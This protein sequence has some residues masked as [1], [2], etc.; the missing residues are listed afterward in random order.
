[1]PLVLAYLTFAAPTWLWL[2]AAAAALLVALHWLS[3][4]RAP[5][6]TFPATRLLAE[7][8]P[9]PTERRRLRDWLLLATRLIILAALIAGFARP[10]W[11]GAR[12]SSAAPAPRHA[13]LL[14]DRS[15]SMRRS[16]QGMRLFEQAKQRAIERLRALQRSGVYVSLV[17]IDES[18]ASLL[19]EPTRNVAVLIDRLRSREV[20]FQRGRAGRALDEARALHERFAAGTN[21]SEPLR[22][23]IISD[24]Q[25]PHWP[26]QRLARLR[27]RGMNVTVHRI[28]GDTTNVALSRLRVR[29]HPPIQHQP[30]EATVRITNFTDKTRRVTARLTGESTKAPAPSHSSASESAKRTGGKEVTRNALTITSPR[31]RL[32]LEPGERRSLT[33]RVTFSRPGPAVLR[34]SLVD[35]ADALPADDTTGAA[36]HVAEAQPVLMITRAEATPDSARY[37]LERALAATHDAAPPRFDVR[38]EPPEAFTTQSFSHEPSTRDAPG[39]STDRAAPPPIVL[40]VDAGGLDAPTREALAGHV[41][42]GGRVFWFVDSAA[43]ADAFNRFA[44]TVPRKSADSRIPRAVWHANT[45][46]TLGSARFD[47]PP[48]EVFGG[49]SR[50]GLLTSSFTRYATLTD[51]GRSRALLRA[52][53]SAALMASWRVGRGRVLVSGLD[54]AP[55]SSDFVKTPWFV[56]FVHESLE[57]LTRRERRTSLRLPGQ[58]LPFNVEAGHNVIAPTGEPLQDASD[59]LSS[60]PGLYRLERAG[61]VRAQQWVAFPP[62]ESDLTPVTRNADD[63]PVQAT[64]QSSTRAAVAGVSRRRHARTAERD[65]GDRDTTS[66]WPG[67]FV[68]GLLML[69]LEPIVHYLTVAPGFAK[70]AIRS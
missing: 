26:R 1:M 42:D 5:E 6:I 4:R 61:T 49:A 47:R 68:L 18:P 30:T 17:M 54:V 10:Q 50:A 35:H 64:T 62:S 60:K 24:T 32:A 3:R 59:T 9:P 67:C 58:P 12:K 40:I 39:D 63:E 25:V 65:P 8:T 29:S 36:V 69:A 20:T 37:F 27:R 7:A 44:E 41:T 48:F 56:P 13:A 52:G 23:E 2:V 31:R 16:E 46:A 51:L 15:A 21:A 53:S 34:A 33:W 55:G 70:T 43:S 11:E 14:V 57:L 19:P 28:A 38:V 22:L 45:R 66:L